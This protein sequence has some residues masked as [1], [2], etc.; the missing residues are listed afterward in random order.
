M[1]RRSSWIVINYAV[2]SNMSGIIHKQTD[3]F[4]IHISGG[5]GSVVNLH[6]TKEIRLIYFF[7]K[8]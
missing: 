4:V 3:L 7:F 5:G 6:G 1:G 8:L 2:F